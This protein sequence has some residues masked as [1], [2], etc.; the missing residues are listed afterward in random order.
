[1]IK[2]WIFIAVVPDK[3]WMREGSS[4]RKRLE[5]LEYNHRGLLYGSAFRTRVMQGQFVVAYVPE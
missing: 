1:M 2:V 3:F 4:G 5:D